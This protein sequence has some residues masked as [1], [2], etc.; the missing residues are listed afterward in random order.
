M[1]NHHSSMPRKGKGKAA[2]AIPATPPAAAGPGISLFGG[3]RLLTGITTTGEAGAISDASEDAPGKKRRLSIASDDDDDDDD[4]DAEE[5]DS[6]D[7]ASAADDDDDDDDEHE[8]SGVKSSEEA[9]EN[10]ESKQ[11]PSPPTTF[12]ALGLDGWLAKQCG[13]VG[14]PAPTEVQAN[15]IP[16][17]LAG[18]DVCGYV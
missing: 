10:D 18:R 13:A 14:M 16:K 12:E 3:S 7:G 17:I 6:S 1:F 2:V 4:D 11:Q 15:C 8:V 9:E 5:A